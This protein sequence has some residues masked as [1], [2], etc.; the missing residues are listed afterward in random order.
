MTERNNL[1]KTMNRSEKTNVLVTSAVLIA[2]GAILHTVVPGIAIKPDFMLATMFV[3]I[4][5][6]PNAKHTVG[7][8]VV[9]GILA[10]LT[11]N[12][13]GGQI[14]S[15]LDKIISALAFMAIYR[16]LATNGK[17]LSLIQYAII[18]F[19][20]TVIS[21]FVFVYTCFGLGKLMGLADTLAVFSNGA[22]ALITAVV[23]PTAVANAFF[24]TL[25]TKV[26]NLVKKGMN[27]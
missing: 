22:F 6:C 3:A 5:L 20:G 26:L 25:L 21:G 15:V 12:F 23:L 27:A 10:A 9:C 4:T 7:I 18:F 17:N 1:T 24:G 11:T 14:P 19:I 8:G 16:S 13:P 2:L